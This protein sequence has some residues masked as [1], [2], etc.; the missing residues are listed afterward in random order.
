MQVFEVKENDKILVVAPHPDDECIGAGGLLVCYPN[1]CKVL[2]LTDGRHGQGDMTPE[3]IR[4]IREKE[5]IKEMEAAG[6]EEYELLGYEDGTLMQH[7]DCLEKTDLSIFTK[8]FVTGIHDGHPDHTA[9][10]LSVLRA[11]RSQG[12]KDMEIY[13]YEVHSLLHQA[14]HM[15]DITDVLDRKLHLIRFH[16]SQLRGLAYDK[17]A[18]SMAEYRALQN[19]R[20]GHYIEAYTCMGPEDSPEDST[21]DL[22]R[23]LQKSVQFYWVLTRWMELKITGHS[24][25]EILEKSGYSRIAVYG[26]AE[27]GRLLCQE[28][29]GTV[30]EVSYVLDKKITQTGR[31]DLSVFAPCQRLPEVE[32]VI[33]TAIYDF[34]EIKKELSEKGFQNILSFRTLLE[35]MDF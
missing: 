31:E 24:V 32:A 30:V 13:L 16:Q 34:D 19:R 2:V 3:K 1:I 8:I 20:E 33:V 17:M 12:I 27:L 23:R 9:A 7:I 15:L 29:F 14:T 5:F 21:I 22:E 10:C 26:Y 6:I 11:L 35:G 28:L 18:K 4:V 25:A